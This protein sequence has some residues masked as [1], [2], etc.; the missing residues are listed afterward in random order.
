MMERIARRSGVPLV[1]CNLVGGNDDLVFD[2]SSTAFDARGRLVGAGRRFEEDFW[3]IDVPG[4]RGPVSERRVGHPRPAQGARAR[5]FATTRASAASRAPSSASR[6]AS[7]RPSRR[8]WRS[9]R[10]APSASSASRCPGRTRPREACATPGT[11]PSAS[12]SGCAVIPIG[13][14][15]RRVPGD[16]RAAGRHGRSRR[17]TEENLQA[18]IRGAILMALS[19]RFGH[20]VL[21]TGN[22]S[23][24]AVG[25]CTL[26]GDMA[27]GYALISDVPKTMVYALAEELNRDGERIPRASIEKPPSAELRPNQKDTDSLPPYADPRSRSSRRS[28][29]SRSRSRGRPGARASRWRSRR[30]SRDRIDRNEYKRRQMPPGPEGHGARLRRGPPLPD[31]AEVPWLRRPSTTPG[32]R[33]RARPTTCCAARIRAL[34]AGLRLLDLGA[35]GGHLGRAVRD[36]CAYL[37]GVEPDPALPASAREGYDDWR[38]TDALAAGHVEPSPSTRSSAPTSSSTCRGPRRCSRRIRGWL[39]AGRHAP[40][41]AAERRERHRAR[42]ARGRPLSRTPTAGSSTARTCAS[43]PAGRPRTLLAAARFRVRAPWPPRRCPTSSAC[44]RPRPGSLARPGPRLRQ[45]LGA[46]LADALRLPVRDRI[47]AAMKATLVVPAYNESSRI[48]ACVRSVAQWVRARARAAGTG[49]RSWSTTAR[50]TTRSRG[51][52]ASRPR[53]SS[54]CASSPTAPTAARAPRSATGVLASSGDPLLISDTDLSTPL[55][56]VGEARRAPAD[57]SGRD[58][59]ARHGAGPRAQAPGRSTASCSGRSATGSSSSSPCPGI[60]DTQCGFKLF[61]GDVARALFFAAARIDRFAWDVEILYLAQRGASRSPRSRSSGSTRRNRRCASC[62]TP[63]RRS[64]TS[65]ASAGCTARRPNPATS[66]ESA[67]RE[68]RR[69]D[70]RVA[71]SPS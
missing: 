19:N 56:G 52:A 33:S 55:V 8:R 3:T 35:A 64:G 46:R 31:R 30:R 23:E 26:Y 24:I 27:G 61:R 10:S 67:R 51:R 45:R 54:T 49:K 59:L 22:K 15:A 39:R 68:R 65:C 36:R 40:R 14:V 2:G 63:S 18:R 66:A 5:P 70:S 69:A 6:A 7:T 37:A 4:G 29:T 42:G 12:A 13:P 17:P 58:R 44:P 43:T 38:A 47:Q 48:E 57:A 16:A 53:R 20:L 9:K 34:P 1:H 41:L 60:Q 25:Y 21:S 62:A 11:S 71:E 50:P 28:W 32:R